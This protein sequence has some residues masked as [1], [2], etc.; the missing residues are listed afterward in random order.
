MELDGRIQAHRW[1]C[2]FCLRT[3][4]AKP[5]RKEWLRSIFQKYF[6]PFVFVAINQILIVLV[7]VMR[8]V[9]GVCSCIKLQLGLNQNV[10]FMENSDPYLFFNMQYKYGQAGP[11][12]YMVL[13]EVDYSNPENFDI[14]LDLQVELSGLTESV[15][16]PVYS[17]VSPF[18]NFISTS[19]TWNEACGSEKAA[20]LDFNAQMKAFTKVEINSD[21][22]QKFDICGEQFVTDISF[23][24]NGEVD[25]TRFRF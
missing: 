23:N 25:A 17:W 10:G 9:I 8:F 19:G 20:L 3:A 15:I 14:M 1:D 7:A 21:C 6:V 5:P 24:V 12:A 16:A 22:C 4:E 18:Q 2:C 13:K 11:P